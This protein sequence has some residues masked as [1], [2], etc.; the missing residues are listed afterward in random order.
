MGILSFGQGT[1]TKERKVLEDNVYSLPN[2][3][4]VVKEIKI[5]QLKGG[6]DYYLQQASK[7]LIIGCS[8]GMGGCL[9]STSA[10][11]LSNDANTIKTIQYVGIGIGVFGLVETIIG[12]TQIGKAGICLSQEKKIYLNNSKEGIG[13]NLKF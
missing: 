12:Y 7:N 8:A 10:G 1:Y 2:Q 3:S 4:M 5:K 13:I 6:S 9:L 11:L